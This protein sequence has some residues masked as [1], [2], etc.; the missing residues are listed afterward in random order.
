MGFAQNTLF[1]LNEIKKEIETMQGIESSDIR[2]G[3]SH[4]MDSLFLSQLYNSFYDEY[5]ESAISSTLL[6]QQYVNSAELTEALLSNKLDFAF[7]PVNVNLQKLKQDTC[8]EYEIITNSSYVLYVSV[9]HP[10]AEFDMVDLGSLHGET[11]IINNEESFDVGS[12]MQAHNRIMLVKYDNSMVMGMIENGNWMFFAGDNLNYDSRRI[13]KLNIVS[14]CSSFDIA[15]VWE[16]RKLQKLPARQ[17][18]KCVL[19]KK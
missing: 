7:M 2:V 17:F 4:Y 11:I 13:K 9:A 8:L 12:F 3:F 10:L 19:G 15:F 6:L 16:K 1:E 14:P 5:H 18:R